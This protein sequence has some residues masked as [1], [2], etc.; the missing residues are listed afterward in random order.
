[1][2][3]GQQYLVVPVAGNGYGGELIAFKA[4]R[5]VKPPSQ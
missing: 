3:N 4:P 2:L 1:M 5:A